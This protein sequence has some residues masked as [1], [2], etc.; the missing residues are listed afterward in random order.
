MLDDEFIGGN[1]TSA[2]PITFY[3][4][5][6]Q[7]IGKMSM[8]I[9][10]VDGNLLT[11]LPVVSRKGIN[12]VYWSPVKRPPRTPQSDAVPFQMRIALMG[13]GMRYPSGD[14]LVRV[15]RGN[16]VYEKTLT[17]YD[18]PD[19][20]YTAEDRKAR[21][22]LQQ[23]GFDLMEDLAYLDRKIKGVRISLAELQSRPG[24]S[25]RVTKQAGNLSAN[26]EEIRDRLLV[27]QYGDLR[28]DTRLREDLG[29]LYGTVAFYD[30]RPT[31]VQT[32]RMNLLETRVRSMEQEVK[33]L[34]EDSLKRLNKALERMDLNRIIPYTREEFESE[35]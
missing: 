12:Q 6:R 20:P 35:E 13:G 8:E 15:T 14:Y 18:N 28:G 9:F 2:I 24:I 7:L 29:F 23:R 17:V 30:G 33:N 10:D 16:E 11:G 25:S 5:K 27:T 19:E 3:M 21:Q 32:D 34:L 4:K 1:S 26:L 22:D 31:R